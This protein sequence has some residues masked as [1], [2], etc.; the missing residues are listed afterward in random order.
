VKLF[1]VE[2]TYF[3]AGFVTVDGAVTQAAPIIGYILR[4]KWTEQRALAYF[5]K[6]RFKV[7]V[8]THQ[9]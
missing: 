5:K 8:I 7:N 3:T 1:R 2:S 4:Q 6:K 9:I